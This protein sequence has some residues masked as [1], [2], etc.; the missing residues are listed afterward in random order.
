[1]RLPFLQDLWKIMF[2]TTRLPRCRRL[3]KV[4]MEVPPETTV[5]P[6]VLGGGGVG[7][8][9]FVG[10]LVGFLFYLVLVGFVVVV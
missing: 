6:G 7:G 2:V 8:G 1:M 4:T 5:R 9:G 3:L 10:L